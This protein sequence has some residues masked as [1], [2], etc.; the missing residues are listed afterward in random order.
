MANQFASI[1]DFQLKL[2]AKLPSAQLAYLQIGEL[3]SMADNVVL[4]LHGYTSSHRF[5][6]ENDPDNTLGS[7]GALVGP[8]RAIDTNKLCVI[9]PNALG[10]SYGST[11]PSSVNPTTQ[12]PWGPTFPKLTFEDQVN[13]QR[14]LL[15]ELG[16]EKLHAVIGLSMGG[17]LRSSGPPSIRTRSRK[18]FLS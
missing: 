8:G 13:A 10:S 15:R 3:N 12:R 16:V 5:V 7:W 4:V 17:F 2:G 11:G 14:L 1:G 18:S 6:L 9:A